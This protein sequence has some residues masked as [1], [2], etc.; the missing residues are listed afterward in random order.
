MNLVYRSP[1][2]KTMQISGSKALL[3]FDHAPQGLRTVDV[4]EVKGFALC[5][6][7]R[8]WVWAKASIIGGPKKGS[9]QIEVSSPEVSQPVAVRYAW[10]DNPVC[11]V[12]SAEGLPLTP[13]R[14]DDF[15]MITDP[16]NPNGLEAQAA[17]RQKEI[18]Q[19]QQKRA[20][21]LKKQQEAK[22]KVGAGKKAA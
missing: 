5:G 2:F 20:E 12:F 6:A 9:N 21:A 22:K 3:T 18:H 14:T 7:D 19:T 16:A 8:K 10:S 4:D 15:S 17:A 13:F 11:N 1:E